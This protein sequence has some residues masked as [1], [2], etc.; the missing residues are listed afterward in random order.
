[1]TR[2]PDEEPFELAE[3]APKVDEVLQSHTIPRTRVF[4]ER[5]IAERVVKARID[6]GL[7][8]FTRIDIQQRFDISDIA[9]STI[10]N[11]LTELVNMGI[12]SV[13]TTS[14]AH[15]YTLAI[16]LAEPA[17]SLDD[18]QSDLESFS[19]TGLNDTPPRLPA[20]AE[21]PAEISEGDPDHPTPQELRYASIMT[22]ATGVVPSDPDRL[23]TA[24]ESDSASTNQY[25][26]PA[27]IVWASAVGS[28]L[29]SIVAISMFGSPPV[30][31][32]FLFVGLGFFSLGIPLSLVSY[33]T[34]EWADP[35]DIRPSD[36]ISIFK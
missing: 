25:A 18:W 19:P 27:K 21:L 13:D 20:H 24:F 33:I 22:A 9:D 5:E 2:H 7:I 35:V 4:N 12:L 3:W 23:Y 6:T 10:V 32:G 1:M 8:V 31:L 30:G 17:V 34:S 11:R 36:F 15:Q 16:P 28:V 14:H 26:T 29:C